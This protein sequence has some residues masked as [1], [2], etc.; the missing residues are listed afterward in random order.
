MSEQDP[1]TQQSSPYKLLEYFVEADAPVFGGRDQEIFDITARLASRGVLVLY[2]PSGIG[3]TSLIW[4]GVFPSARKLDWECVYLRTL[5]D[6]VADLSSAL[7]EQLGLDARQGETPLQLADRLAARNSTRPLLIAL[8]QFEEF[9]IRFQNDAALKE[10]F[11]ET[12]GLIVSRNDIDCRI[13]FSLREDY[14]AK[15]DEFSAKLPQLLE[16]R[17]RIN[18]LTAFGAR[19]AITLP[20]LAQRIPFDARLVSDLLTHLAAFD[21]DPAILQIMCSELVRVALER[22]PESLTLRSDDLLKLGGIEGMFG[23]YLDKAVDEVG[24]DM[25]LVMRLVLDVL[26]S[27]ER[28]KRAIRII[29]LKAEP[30]L[31]SDEELEAVVQALHVHRIVRRDRRGNEDWFEFMH[32][33]LVDIV[34]EWMHADINFFN[35]VSAR[36]LAGFSKRNPIWRTNPEAL[37]TEGQLKTIIEPYS[38]RLRLDR[39]QIKFLILS[40]MY[41][42]SPLLASWASRYSERRTMATLSAQL[43][44]DK[45]ALRIGALRA[46]AALEWQPS[47][48]ILDRCIAFGLHDPREV[49]RRAAGAVLA[50][51]ATR[52]ERDLMF[53]AVTRPATRNAALQL[54]A[55]LSAVDRTAGSIGMMERLRIRRIRRIRELDEHADLRA[56][57]ARWG[58]IYG[59]AASGIWCASIGPLWIFLFSSIQY[60]TDDAVMLLRGIA[61]LLYPIVCV[62]GGLLGYRISLR[63]AS[64]DILGHKENWVLDLLSEWAFWV[65]IPLY[66]LFVWVLGGLA[67]ASAKQMVALLA[68]PI[69][70]WLC[71]SSVSVAVAQLCI[72]K[73]QRRATVILWGIA[74]AMT[75]PVLLATATAYLAYRLFD[76]ASILDRIYSSGL[77]LVLLGTSTSMAFVFSL[78]FPRMQ[79]KWPGIVVTQ[80]TY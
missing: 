18:A 22:S 73:S 27:K 33:R 12:I 30:F 70:Y 55:D 10:A 69:A 63:A 58:G 36:D 40:C 50:R 5:T 71:A 68:L 62:I 25:A 21:F 43:R 4:A 67:N 48:R 74:T 59:L 64:G 35:F 23:T 20:L 39:W 32:E 3:K 41:R 45:E 8:D 37:L 26:I 47:S 57:R 31:A 66:V 6:P 56:R 42:Q 46:L 53:D 7:T 54:C 60:S 79:F 61:V 11:V 1:S 13:L 49:V 34:L 51:H 75:A 2:G 52:R 17:Y 80:V 77:A 28:T 16:N 72:G 24:T 65:V 29:D 38:A 76:D 15:L 14:L 78:A 19:Q 9:F 44:S